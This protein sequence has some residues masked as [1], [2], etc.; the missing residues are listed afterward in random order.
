MNW[1]ERGFALHR[2]WAAEDGARRSRERAE[3]LEDAMATAE[4]SGAF[5]D[6]RLGNLED[7]K[8]AGLLN[9]TGL[10]LGAFG[11]FGHFIFHNGEESLL[12]YNRAGGGKG[13][14]LIQPNLAHSNDRTLIVVDAKDGEL[15]FSSAAHRRDTLGTEVIY[16]NPYGLHGLPNTKINPFYRLIEVVQS[17]GSPDGEAEAICEI[18]LPAPSR[19][20]AGDWPRKGAIELTA[21]RAEFLAHF[22]PIRCTPSEIWRFCNGD[23]EHFKMQ[24]SLMASCEIE[25]IERRARSFDSMRMNA[26]KQWEAIRSEASTAFNVF[27]PGKSLGDACASHDIDLTRAKREKMTIY[28]ILPANRIDVAKAWVSM[29]IAMMTEVIAAARGPVRTTFIVDE[30][31]EPAARAQHPA[32]AAALSGLGVSYWFFAQGRNSLTS[33]WSKEQVKD[34][35]DQVGIITMKSVWEPDLLK[36]IELWSGTKTI[37]QGGVN[38]AGGVVQTASANLSETKRPVLQA[39]D[40]IALGP[41]RQVIRVASMP[42]LLISDAVPYFT[43]DPWRT[44]VRDVRDLHKGISE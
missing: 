13:T 30:F 44:Q 14:T 3:E 2:G 42:H 31:A 20:S 34:I 12:T 23:N 24:F 18:A 7:C 5:G 16:L 21:M 6:G 28:I 19:H 15:A 9:S 25:S 36:D 29:L 8:K 11:A 4:P 41:T 38:H 32:L 1:M 27:E 26:E 10:F 40:V 43:V 22:D 37:L 17:G 35:E 39:G 33:Q